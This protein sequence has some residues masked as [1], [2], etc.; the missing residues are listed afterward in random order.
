MILLVNINDKNMSVECK[1]DSIDNSD[2]KFTSS[3]K[4]IRIPY[5]DENGNN[6]QFTIYK[7]A[8]AIH[9][10]P[11][12]NMINKGSFRISNMQNKSQFLKELWDVM[13]NVI[14]K[15]RCKIPALASKA[16]WLLFWSEKIHQQ[17]ATQINSIVKKIE[18]DK[19]VE[20]VYVNSPQIFI[21]WK[22]SVSIDVNNGEGIWNLL[23]RVWLWTSFSLWAFR[24]INSQVLNEKDVL[25][26]NG[27]Y[28]LPL[29]S[30]SVR[31]W[32]NLNSILLWYD[33]S[34]KFAQQ[35]FEY[36]RSYNP[37]F[38][39]FK[40][41]WELYIWT[42][43]LIPFWSTGFYNTPT[44]SIAS[45]PVTENKIS[46]V[47]K[48]A[49]KQEVSK[50]AAKVE[51]KEKK[52][53]FNFQNWIDSIE[54]VS[55]ELKWKI[56]VLDPWHGWPD[57]W[58]H[59]IA[60]DSSWNPIKD[61]NSRVKYISHGKTRRVD[62]PS[63]W[64]G[65]LHVYESLVAVD[66]AYRLAKELK[67]RWAAVYITRYNKTTGIIDEANMSTPSTSE[68]VYSD[69]LKSWKYSRRGNSKRLRKW[70]S[71]ANSI[72]KKYGSSKDMYFLS[73][74]ADSQVKW[75]ELPMNIKYYQW[76]HGVN[77][78]GRDFA[79][80]LAKWIWN[81][82]NKNTVASWQWLY[83]VDKHYNNIWNAV[84][85][86]LANMNSKNSAYTLRQPWWNGIFWRQDYADAIIDGLID[87]FQ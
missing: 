85:I 2:L 84:L 78:T 82:R 50:P 10:W 38:K 6:Y 19:V 4:W 52:W 60:Q 63:K 79:R 69:S 12:W 68:D 35:I 25:V 56:F 49:S 81:F 54:V 72:V 53:K 51:Y 28:E 14:W 80:N 31:A 22:S 71:I 45:V 75:S 36:N 67:Q 27:R 44:I 64:S 21:Y 76:R 73:L 9:K 18:H 13:N 30:H 39:N 24:N 70:A 86:E 42:K 65:Y 47:S 87:M 55:E 20:K 32:E 3:K 57:L 23:N 5:I 77:T 8:I 61:R 66:I 37:E 26:E 1:R 74:H 43:I 33:L 11:A 16:H 46:N 29:L 59:P 15:D 17:T 62:V 83:I 58:A 41:K 7:N 40:H 48:I 34:P